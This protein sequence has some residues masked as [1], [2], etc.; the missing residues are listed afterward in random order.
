VSTAAAPRALLLVVALVVIAL[1]VRLATAGVL[2]DIVA[3]PAKTSHELVV[4]VQDDP[5]FVRLPSSYGGRGTSQVMPARLGYE[6]LATLGV[7]ILRIAIH[8]AAVE[9]SPS[10]TA[11]AW[12][13]YDAAIARARAA[14][15]T[16]QLALT[17]PAP[18]FAT[19]DHSIGAN[20]PS[21]S[22]YARFADAAATR[23]RGLVNTYS[24][25]NEPNW[26]NLLQPHRIAPL[27]YRR[28][29]EAGYAAVKRA[30][31]S[32]SVLIG[33]LAPMS[34]QGHANPPLRFLRE[35]TCNGAATHPRGRC[36]PLIADGFAL[37]PYTLR[38]PPTFPGAG[39]DDVT[40]GSLPRL[41][42]AL[43]QLARAG[44]LST[45]S[46]QPPPLYLTEYGWRA[47][48]RMSESQRASFAASGFALAARQPQVKEIVWYQLAAPPPNPERIWDTALLTNLGAPRP[49]FNALR[50]WI[51]NEPR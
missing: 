33:E 35:M 20:E 37:H 6:R 4:G 18:A 42:H 29:Y 14:G 8:W 43:A 24:I 38:S 5:V 34:E 45:K 21:A 27:L 46:G 1:L 25:W 10:A 36:A 7:R 50:A 32:A 30:D 47:Q 17:G 49:A 26:W 44:A 41:V 48:Q 19:A 22:A 40:T 9:P 13:Y 51:A 28:L 2:S 3:G 11:G 39:R 16:V 23:Y 31:A 12:G 15:L